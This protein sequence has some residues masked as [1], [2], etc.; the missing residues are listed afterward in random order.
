ML[1]SEKIQTADINVGDRVMLATELCW[2]LNCDDSFEMSEQNNY[3]DDFLNLK[4]VT[5]MR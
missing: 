3:K 1:I 4:N 5:N 2:R